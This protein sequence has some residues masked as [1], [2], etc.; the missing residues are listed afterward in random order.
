[1]RTENINKITNKKAKTTLRLF[2][3]TSLPLSSQFEGETLFSASRWAYRTAKKV[4]TVFSK[5]RAIPRRWDALVRKLF[6][7]HHN[8]WIEAAEI[9]FLGIKNRDLGVSRF[10]AILTFK[11]K[12]MR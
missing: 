5:Y 11:E 3:N 4:Q 8:Y 2:L 12:Q 7:V 9:L 10:S 1:V 6:L